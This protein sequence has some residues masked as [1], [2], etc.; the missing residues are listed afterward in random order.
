MSIITDQML[1]E[2]A[3]KKSE[4]STIIKMIGREPNPLELGLFGSLWSVM[5]LAY[6]YGGINLHGFWFIGVPHN[7]GTIIA[8]FVANPSAPSW[9]GWLFTVI[10]GLVQTFFVVMRARFVWWPLHPLGFAISTFSILSLIH[11]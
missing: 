4:F 3:L 8:Q 1:N 2:L 5:V 9:D 11:I 7:A 6:R 10:G